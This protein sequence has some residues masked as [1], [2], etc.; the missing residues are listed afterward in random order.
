MRSQIEVILPKSI[1]LSEANISYM[2]SGVKIVSLLAM[3]LCSFRLKEKK[4]AALLLGMSLIGMA[5]SVRFVLH[6]VLSVY[7][8]Y[9]LVGTFTTTLAFFSISIM[10][11]RRMRAMAVHTRSTNLVGEIAMAAVRVT[12]AIVMLCVAGIGADLH[13]VGQVVLLMF[14]VCLLVGAIVYYRNANTFYE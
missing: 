9:A 3:L 11:L 5:M 4:Y 13:L 6:F 10:S 12:I 7:I 2:M 8:V 14:S 1:D